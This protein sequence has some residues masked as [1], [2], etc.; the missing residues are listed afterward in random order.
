MNT[1]LLRNLWRDYSRLMGDL[2]SKAVMKDGLEILEKMDDIASQLDEI[3]FDD[4]FQKDL[5]DANK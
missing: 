1:E 2:V 5:H 4:R 3:I